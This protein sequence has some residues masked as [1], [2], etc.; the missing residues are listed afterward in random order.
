MDRVNV[1]GSFGD[2]TF[3]IVVSDFESCLCRI[4]DKTMSLDDGR[5]PTLL[6]FLLLTTDLFIPTICPAQNLL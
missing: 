2:T 3:R 6:F 4:R 1:A 5:L